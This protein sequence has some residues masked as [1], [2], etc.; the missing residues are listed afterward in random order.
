VAESRK[1]IDQAD[2]E[3]R[4]LNTE[5]EASWQ[6][7]NQEI[8]R[9]ANDIDKAE[10]REHVEKLE[11]ELRASVRKTTSIS[12]DRGKPDDRAKKLALRGWLK[13]GTDK[14][15]TAEER[16]ACERV[17][18]SPFSKSITQRCAED[19]AMLVGSS[20]HGQELG[21]WYPGLAGYIDDAL[22]AYGNVFQTS[23]LMQTFNG[24]QI[25]VPTLNGTAQK[26]TIV[27]EG[28]TI[29]PADLTTGSVTFNA[30]K[31]A[32]AV[33]FSAELLQDSLIN[34]EAYLAQQLA[35]RFYRGL[36]T[37]FVTGDGSS[38]PQ[39]ITVGATDS[40]VTL[41]GTGATAAISADNL[42]DTIH[43]VD[44]LYR[45]QNAAWL[46]H[47]TTLAKVRKLKDSNGQ[48]LWV[49]GGG[50]SNSLTQGNPDRLL[51]YPV[52]V[53]QDMPQLGTATNKVL[54][55]GDLSKYYIRQVLDV[56]L[57]RLDELYAMSGEIGLVAIARFDGKLVDAGTHPV[58]TVANP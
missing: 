29:S 56:S 31:Y 10:R 58:V 27:G 12:S 57:Q 37:H 42:I 16:D 26:A 47:D 2:A 28:S 17:G 34:L 53:N 1:L 3:Q 54:V 46:M 41:S 48:Y 7:Y 19:R 40:G 36:N 8:D 24:I 15:L 38:K 14:P 25:S 44:P 30:Y 9:L 50:F 39:G 23:T 18:Y 35:Q 13:G 45:N 55:F 49:T 33:V 20:T 21:V 43:A 32:S 11:A 4:N 52:Y 5:E 22:K 51:G 6:K